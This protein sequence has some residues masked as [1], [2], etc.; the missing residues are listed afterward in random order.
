MDFAAYEEQVSGIYAALSGLRHEIHDLIAEGDK[1][2]YRST[3][4]G[5]HAG[6]LLGVPPTGKEVTISAMAI[7]RIVAGKVA[8]VW[9][10]P[11]MMSLMQQIGALPPL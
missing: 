4:R 8:E 3:N 10:M 5:T 6:E 7:I 1:V 9:V 2:V 11:D